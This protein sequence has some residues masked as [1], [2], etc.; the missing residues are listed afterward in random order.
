MAFACPKCGGEVSRQHSAGVQQAGG[1]VG[2]LIFAALA[3][4]TCAKC[5]KL[6]RSDFSPADRA[7]M[8]R[9]SALMVGG[10]VLLFG[11]VIAIVVGVN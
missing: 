9:N 4:L 5:G 7:V 6:A 1:L 2:A 8:N 10:A 11:V 3:S